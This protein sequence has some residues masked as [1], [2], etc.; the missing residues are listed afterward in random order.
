MVISKTKVKTEVLTMV[1]AHSCQLKKPNDSMVK[2]TKQWTKTSIEAS[3]RNLVK[4]RVAAVY[5][6]PAKVFL[7]L[8]GITAGEFSLLVKYAITRLRE[9]ST[10]TRVPVN[11]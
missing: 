2:N 11:P 7:R 6:F 3:I 1:S 4:P 8:N 5:Q 10:M 9:G